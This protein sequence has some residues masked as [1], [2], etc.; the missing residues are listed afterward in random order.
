MWKKKKKLGLNSL[1]SEIF[2]NMFASGSY[3]ARM[4]DS[5]FGCIVLVLGQNGFVR[6]LFGKRWIC[7]WNILKGKASDSPGL[8]SS[9]ILNRH[10][11][12]K[13][14]IRNKGRIVI[15]VFIILKFF[16]NRSEG[17]KGWI[18]FYIWGLYNE[19][20]WYIKRSG[21]VLGP[22]RGNWEKCIL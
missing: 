22:V 14:S 18:F 4:D 1:Q 10:C 13:E 12:E 19:H 7:D 11:L 16:K 8:F 21:Q 2:K 3:L 5:R 6:H 17:E 20:H 15:N 9:N